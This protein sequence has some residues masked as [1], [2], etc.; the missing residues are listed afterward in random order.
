MR[1]LPGVRLPHIPADASPAWA[2]FVLFMDD[3]ARR[4]RA[5]AALNAAGIGATVSYPQAL[6]DVP[7]ARALL[8]G[9]AGNQEGSRK[10]AASVV[11]LPTHAYV[12]KDLGARV[13]D[14]IAR[15]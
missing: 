4:T 2:R 10:V 3:P 7:E 6:A 14:V 13:R 1:D 8:S 15:V 12:P 11:T 5:I 9:D